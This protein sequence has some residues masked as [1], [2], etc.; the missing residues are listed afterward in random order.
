MEKLLQNYI[1]L[2]PNQPQIIDDILI[3][4]QRTKLRLMVKVALQKIY[5]K[6]NKFV[7]CGKLIYNKLFIY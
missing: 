3:G 1:N 4:K 2:I 7:E 6:I 5:K